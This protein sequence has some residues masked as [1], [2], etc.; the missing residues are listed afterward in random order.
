M[1]EMLLKR[2]EAAAKLRVS[3]ATL[4]R[5]IR[6]GKIQVRRIGG[7]IRIEPDALDAVGR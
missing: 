4:D 7:S 3:L 6:A 1:H 2:A 5:L